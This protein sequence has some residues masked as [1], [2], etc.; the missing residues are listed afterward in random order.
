MQ[1]EEAYR[2]SQNIIIFNVILLSDK[3]KHHTVGKKTE[4]VVISSDIQFHPIPIVPYDAT[5]I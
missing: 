5:S 3:V 2:H 4:R 1:Y